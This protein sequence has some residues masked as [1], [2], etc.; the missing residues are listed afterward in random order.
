MKLSELARRTEVSP[1]SIKYYLRLG[2][3]TPGQ[4]RNAT[5][6]TYTEAHVHRLALITWLRRE[7]DLPL[8]V[9]TELTS[10]ID[11]E[12][13]S[14]LELMGLCQRTAS[15]PG[16]PDTVGTEAAD[17][18]VS[19]TRSSSEQPPR[20]DADDGDAAVR[21]ALAAL[22]WPD[23]SPT[24][25]TAVAAALADLAAAGYTVD[26][27]TVLLHARALEEIA[28]TNTLPI[29]DDLTRDEIALAV[30]RGI[31]LHN[32]LLVSMSGLVHAAMSAQARRQGG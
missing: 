20:G 15:H 13:V 6:A 25:R 12:T 7:L 3:L 24:A 8:A 23:V 29:S 28:R 2:V 26:A 27:D 4:K 18:P 32:R 11:D 30:I 1:A 17:P 22:D 19:D 31:T 16:V 14:N 5:T 9:I 21:S 10:A